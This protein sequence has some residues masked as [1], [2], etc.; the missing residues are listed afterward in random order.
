MK[1]QTIGRALGI[2]LRVAGRIAGQRIAAG[3]QSD[4]APSPATA[5]AA[6]ATPGAEARAPEAN[7]ADGRAAGRA[8]GRTTHGV[9]R[10][11]GGFL[12]PF[13]RVGGIVWLEVTGAFFFLFVLVFA[14]ALWRMRAS[15]A[16]GE[17]HPRFLIFAAIMVVFLYL[18]V[19]SFWRAR[20][21]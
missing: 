21:R 5:A 14:Q 3:E 2:G 15:W 1:P 7:P 8:A 11:V 16:L 19:S 10:G 6:Q 18:S 9:A 4:G 12:R 17:N 13:R 20:K